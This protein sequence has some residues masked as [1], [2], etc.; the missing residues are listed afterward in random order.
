MI[1]MRTK[2]EIEADLKRWDF[3]KILVKKFKQE[4]ADLVS[5]SKPKKE[6]NP[7]DL[8]GDGDVDKDDRSI[9]G[10]VLASGRRRKSKKNK[11]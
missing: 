10:K 4:L 7:L 5:S 1:K 3:N 2:E 6:K 11:K 9:A 8:D